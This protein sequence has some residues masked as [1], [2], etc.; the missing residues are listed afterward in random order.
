MAVLGVPLRPCCI[1]KAFSCRMMW[2]ISEGEDCKSVCNWVWCSVV[3]SPWQEMPADVPLYGLHGM[4]FM[5]WLLLKG[6]G[7]TMEQYTATYVCLS[8]MS[9]YI[10]SQ[11]RRLHCMC[12]VRGLN[13]GPITL[14]TYVCIY[15]KT[16]HILVNLLK[17]CLLSFVLVT[18]LFEH[19]MTLLAPVIEHRLLADLFCSTLIFDLM[20][21]QC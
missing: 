14:H 6:S 3:T 4:T 18:G 16:T 13:L 15:C 17:N 1:V 5:Y 8:T 9:F 19:C 11:Y 2:C 20:S 10:G 7:C 12:A 21:V